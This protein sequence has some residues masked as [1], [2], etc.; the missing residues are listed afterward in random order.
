[1]TAEERELLNIIRNDPNPA[2]AM[3]IVLD[4]MT[5]YLAE[6]RENEQQQIFLL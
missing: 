1:M 5:E 2:E 3:K 6:K 4:I